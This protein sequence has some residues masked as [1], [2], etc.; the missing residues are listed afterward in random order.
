[1]RLSRVSSTCPTATTRPMPASGDG[2]AAVARILQRRQAALRF[3]AGHR[4]RHPADDRG[5]A[6]DPRPARP[7]D[8]GHRRRP[9]RPRAAPAAPAARPPRR[10]GSSASWPRRSPSSPASTGPRA[11]PA[12]PACSRPSPKARPSSTW[13]RSRASSRTRRSR[14]KRASAAR[15]SYVGFVLARGQPVRQVDLGPAQP[16][17]D[18]VR[19]WRHAIDAG[20]ASPA[21]ETLRRLVWEPLARHFPPGTTTVILAPDWRLDRRPLGG[22]AR[23][24]AR[25]GAPGAVRPGH[26][27]ACPV[28]PRSPD[29]A[30]AERPDDRGLVLAVGGV[31]YDQD[32][33]PIDDE[34]TRLD[35]LAAPPGRDPARPRATAG[36]SL[37]GTLQE[38]DAVARLAAPAIARPAP[39]RR[40]EH[41]AAAPRAAPRPLGPHRHP[42]L[43]RRSRRP[44]RPADPIP[45]S[46][47]SMGRERARRR[48]AQPAGPLGPGP[49]RGQPAAPRQATTPGAT[50]WGILT[51]EAIAGL[52]LQD[53]E[54]VVLSACET[55]LGLDRR[56]RGRLRPPARL[57]PGRR[58]QRRRQPLEGGRRG[59]GGPDGD[60]LRP[61]LAAE[62]AADRGAAG[63]PVD[64]LPPSRAGR[65][66]SP[67]PAARPTSTSWC[68]AP[69]RSPGGGGP[70]PLE[71]SRTG[72]AMG[73]VRP[74]GLGKVRARMRNR[75]RHPHDNGA[76][77]GD[78]SRSWRSPGSAAANRWRPAPG[79]GEAE[80]LQGPFH[81]RIDD[82]AN[83]ARRNL[84]LDQGG[85]LPLKAHDRFR[86]E[87]KLNRPAYLYV[88]WIGSDGKVAPDLSL[89]S[90]ATG[91][92]APPRKARR[93]GSTCR[94]RPTR[95]GRSRRATRASRRSSCWHA[96]T[97]PCRATSIWP[98]WLAGLPVPNRRPGLD[99]AV[100]I[101]NGREVTLDPQG[102]RRAQLQDPQERRS[103]APHPPAVAGQ[104]AAAGRLQ[105]GRAVPQSRVRTTT[106]ARRGP[107]DPAPLFVAG[108]STTAVNSFGSR[109]AGLRPNGRNSVPRAGSSP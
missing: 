69:S 64:A 84:R 58:P 103:R 80:P 72:E 32:P 4:P 12:Y 96:S 67:G 16:I 25:D 78:W 44:L 22:L 98:G 40:G 19:P 61:A 11:K 36:R 88:F 38:L 10:S 109:E 97:A 2:K 18:A 81:L 42:R 105:P 65:A 48:P 27:P 20:Q 28:P 14:E 93:T 83:P 77:A 49:G 52:P 30:G 24:P 63:G 95:P 55:G 34:T 107:P 56:R 59:D 31:A 62:Q 35:L 53:L 13:S 7:A 108:L 99:T 90:R 79:H 82:P 75:P 85:A 15:P 6:R 47:P 92:A 51:A 66:S 73:G 33:R 3:R 60:L 91:T 86:I 54:L 23:R 100:W 17:D 94:R 106:S 102:P 29:G 37:P 8:A 87:A 101:E 43:L 1:M 68:S 50:T 26:R 89:G 45:S 104:G 39:G 41:G 5:L 71:G 76:Y 70:G 21:A 74:L 46:S 9:R 57:P